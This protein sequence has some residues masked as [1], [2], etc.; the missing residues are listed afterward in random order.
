MSR[1]RAVPILVTKTSN[2]NYNPFVNAPAEWKAAVNGALPRNFEQA[3][4]FGQR[5][6]NSAEIVWSCKGAGS[7]CAV[8]GVS[9]ASV[10]NSVRKQ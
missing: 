1:C 7:Y 4:I 8:L 6:V 3:S 5:P 10:D 2:S 9:P